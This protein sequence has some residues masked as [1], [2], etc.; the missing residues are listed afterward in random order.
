MSDR[1]TQFEQFRP[2]IAEDE[3]FAAT[4]AEN[5]VVSFAGRSVINEETHK[6]DGFPIKFSLLDGS[7]V[8]LI[9]DAYAFAELQKLSVAVDVVNQELANASSAKKH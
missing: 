7:S 4:K 1:A 2:I 8:V 9:S 3:I 6:L 5:V